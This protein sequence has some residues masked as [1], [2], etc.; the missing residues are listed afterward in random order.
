MMDFW[1]SCGHHLLDRA[2]GGGLAVTDEFLKAYFVRPELTPPPDACALERKLHGAL[3]AEPRRP[4][5]AADISA[6][7]D[8]DA[9]E[10]WQLV[11]AFR[12]LLLRFPTLEAAY[13]AL[14]RG[15]AVTLPPLFVN[16][17]AHVILRNALDGCDDPFVLRAGELFFRPQRIMPDQQS[18]IATDEEW[19]ASAHPESVAPLLSLLD[20][21]AEA[22][23][24]I[25]DDAN[26]ASYWR[27]SDMFDLGLDLSAAG[28]GRAALAEAMTRWIRHLLA[29]DVTIEPLGELRDARFTWYVGLDAEATKI[30]DRLWNDGFLDDGMSGRVVALFQLVFSDPTA[31]VDGRM[32]EPVYLILAASPDRILRMKPQNLITGLPVRHLEAA[33]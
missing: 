30:G 5:D 22:K 26:A 16:Q 29:V 7:A 11:L 24:E 4:I 15:G 1:I 14:M 13:L 17:L 23:L 25:M 20:M 3:L 33:S 32:N 19:I 9:R 27:R 2:P 28:R 8:P 6:I 18:M 31:I 12:E 21:A 10:N